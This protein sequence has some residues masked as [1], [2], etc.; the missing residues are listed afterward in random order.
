MQ[1]GVQDKINTAAKNVPSMKNHLDKLQRDLVAE[2][3]L[4]KVG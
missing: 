2:G 3:D 4:V 1:R